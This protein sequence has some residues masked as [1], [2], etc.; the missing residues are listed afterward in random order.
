MGG[1]HRNEAANVHFQVLVGR[2]EKVRDEEVRRKKRKIMK[3][4][5]KEEYVNMGSLKLEWGF[6]L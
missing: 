4:A 3:E 5:R 6:T 1:T 2:E